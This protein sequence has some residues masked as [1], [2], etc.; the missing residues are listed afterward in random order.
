M[1]RRVYF[2]IGDLLACIVAGAA[3]GWL[4]RLAVSGDWLVV[5]G[6]ATG[7]AL[8]MLAGMVAG[9]LF[10]PFFGSIELLLPATLSG[11][12]AGMGVGILHA[13]AAIGPADAAWTGALVGIACLV[14]TYLL[15]ARLH[16]EV[17]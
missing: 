14:F 9:L 4:A 15:Q 12:L 6:M 17:Q 16:G 3:A 1:E 8:G 10:A 5:L 11:M 13:W 7:A 2:L